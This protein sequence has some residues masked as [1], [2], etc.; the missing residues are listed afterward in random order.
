MLRQ[1]RN[2]PL[3][4]RS[5]F[6]SGSE[7]SSLRDEEQSVI[8]KRQ[9]YKICILTIKIISG[10]HHGNVKQNKNQKYPF[11]YPEFKLVDDQL[12]PVSECGQL[13]VTCNL[14]IVA[15]VQ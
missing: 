9:V 2:I 4:K 15:V 14:E 5:R 10:K 13:S 6:M 11:S 7:G 12:S 3:L 1:K 8:E